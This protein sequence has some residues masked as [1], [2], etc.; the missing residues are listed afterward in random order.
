MKLAKWTILT[1]FFSGLIVSCGSKNEAY[2]DIGVSRELA[3]FRKESLSNVNY[4]LFVEIPEEYTEPIRGEESIQ[5]DLS[6]LSR[7]VVLDFK[8]PEGYVEE[9][10]VNGANADFEFRNEHII[11]DEDYFD[12]GANEI[13]IKFRLGETSL[14]RN[15]DYLYTLFVP[16]RA[17]TAFPCFDQP[18]L[19]ASYDLSLAIPVDWQAVANGPLIEEFITGDKKKLTFGQT[20]PISTYLFDFVAGEFAVVEQEKDGRVMKML[21]RETDSLKVES[22]LEQIFELHHRS[23]QWLEEYTGIDYP[24]QKFDFALIPS[25]QYG[26]MEHPGAITYKAESLFLNESASQNQLLRRASLIAHETAHMWFGDLV[27]MDWFN[28][29]WMKEVFANFMAAKI[30]HPSFPEIDHD[31]RF[32]LAHYPSAYAIDRSQGAHAIQ[33]ELANL[34]DA[35]TLYGAIIYQKA[36][37]VMRMLERIIGEEPF[38]EGIKTYLTDYAYANATWDDLISILDELT[39]EDLDEW[40]ELWIKTKGMP[41]VVPLIRENEDS[42]IRKFSYFQFDPNGDIYRPQDLSVV[43]L[44]N[45]SIYNYDVELR[46]QR[47]DIDSAKGLKHATFVMSNSKGYG[48]GYFPMGPQ[49]TRRWLDHIE[50]FEL[51]LHRGVGWLSLYESMVRRAVSTEDYLKTVVRNLPVEKDPL[52]QSFMLRSMQTVFWQMINEEDRMINTEGLE[53]LLWSRM[54]NLEDNRLKRNY[55]SAYRSICLSEKG[56]ER[57]YMVWQGEIEVDGLS[58]STNDM[59]EIACALAIRNHP[60]SNEILKEQLARISNKDRQERLSF[61][62]P[63]LSSDKQERDSFFESLKEVENR[64]HESWVQTAIGYLHH[65]L[66]ANE[67][68]EY[69]TP[70]LEMLE[71]IQQT[72]D[73]FFPKRVLDNTFSGHSSYESVDAIRQFLYRNNHY[74]KN[75]KNKILQS[76]DMTFRAEERLSDRADTVKIVVFE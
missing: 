67:S 19:K 15:E 53:D 11:L 56:V 3:D 55:F 16:E 36:P 8:V 69:I 9:V 45:D 31:L 27:T 35:G 66:R 59:T 76:A 32:L 48:Y 65:P 50:D 63:S 13:K 40:S 49:T 54:V 6:D 43:L 14:N 29:V 64:H 41:R 60:G 42:T 12:L 72:G 7:E 22:N 34:N 73:I 37:I 5:F 18:N 20:K 21:H 46:G 17:R 39:D 24:F 4:Q 61:L 75:L 28:D 62:I 1:L 57:L 30:V 74:P 51:G 33:Q 58:L 52:L 26:G 44:A 70:T 23:L 47:I 38:R 71:E 10:M 25:F 68:V 2:F